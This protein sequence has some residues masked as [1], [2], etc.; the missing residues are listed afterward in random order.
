MTDVEIEPPAEHAGVPEHASLRAASKDGNN[1]D[2]GAKLAFNEVSAARG[3][4][5]RF[6]GCEVMRI[7]SAMLESL[8]SVK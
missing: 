4:L 2:T 7:V 8:T 3:Y 1:D 6:P 5:G